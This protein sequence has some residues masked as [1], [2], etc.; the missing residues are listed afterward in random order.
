MSER[1]PDRMIEPDPAK[2][3]PAGAAPTGGAQPAGN[4]QRAGVSSGTDDAPAEAIVAIPLR[5]PWRNVI[6]VLLL[7]GLAVFVLDAAQRPDYGWPDV[8]KYIFDR[9]ISQAAWVTLWLT[10]YSM[11]GAIVI[12]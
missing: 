7:L 12:G 8:G 3:L 4:A 5:H 10:I 2:P 1:E 6:A 11:I 9:R